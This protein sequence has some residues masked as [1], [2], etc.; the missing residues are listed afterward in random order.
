M[1]VAQILSVVTSSQENSEI[2]R[3][4]LFSFLPG[5]GPDYFFAAFCYPAQF[6]LPSSPLSIHKA[7]QSVRNTD[8]SKDTCDAFLFPSFFP[9]SLTCRVSLVQ[10]GRAHV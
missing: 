5:G 10:I 7:S 8:F 6:F 1:P 4:S 2:F 3:C 9:C